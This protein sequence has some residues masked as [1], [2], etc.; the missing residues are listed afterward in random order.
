M[1]ARLPAQGGLLVCQLFEDV[2]RLTLYTTA[3]AEPWLPL[4]RSHIYPRKR[5]RVTFG[6]SL[7]RCQPRE[8][9]APAYVTPEA[10][11]HALPSVLAS[12]LQHRDC[13]Q[14]P[15]STRARQGIPK[16]QTGGILANHGFL[17]DHLCWAL[18]R[19]RGPSAAKLVP[20]TSVQHT[21]A[22]PPAQ[23]TCL[24]VC[25]PQ[26]ERTHC[27]QRPLHALQAP[28]QDLPPAHRLCIPES[29]FTGIYWGFT[30]RTPSH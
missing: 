9:D 24:M 20:L 1:C 3:S 22:Q 5:R 6:M 19:P 18:L 12:L 23:G 16:G 17:G 21:C 11:A 26:T 2:C 8:A 29:G 4:I 25:A 14:S 15:L 27:R 10:Q 7:N 13:V 30:P 28:G